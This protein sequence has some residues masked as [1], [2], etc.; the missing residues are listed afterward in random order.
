MRESDG[1]SKFDTKLIRF[2]LPPK[3][4]F[5][6]TSFVFTSGREGKSIEQIYQKK[7]QSGADT[8]VLSAGWSWLETLMFFE[9]KNG[10]PMLIKHQY[11]EGGRSKKVFFFTHKVLHQ[12]SPACYRVIMVYLLEFHED[13][14]W[15]SAAEPFT[16]CVEN[17]PYAAIL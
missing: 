3:S 4:V 9:G 14:L 16:R 6:A 11:L 15:F 10:L 1:V 8:P 13:S 12:R 17:P 2:S 5:W 7:T